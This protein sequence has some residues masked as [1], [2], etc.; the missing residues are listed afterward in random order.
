MPDNYYHR[1]NITIRDAR[2]LCTV[3]GWKACYW[4]KFQ[5][6]VR[7]LEILKMSY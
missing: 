5:L 4:D 1:Q 2:N 3:L 7:L 6:A